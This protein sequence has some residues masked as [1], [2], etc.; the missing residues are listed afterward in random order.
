[1]RLS[2]AKAS[3]YGD[4]KPASAKDRVLL[5]HQQVL[6]YLPLP[7][8]GLF[9]LINVVIPYCFGSHV[10]VFA[11]HTHHVKL[12]S[13]Q[14]N[15]RMRGIASPPPPFTHTLPHTATLPPRTPTRSHTLPHPPSHS[16][17][18]SPPHFQLFRTTRLPHVDTSKLPPFHSSTPPLAHPHFS[19]QICDTIQLFLTDQVEVS[20]PDA[21]ATLNVSVAISTLDLRAVW[22][23]GAFNLTEHVSGL[24]IMC[25]RGETPLPTTHILS[26][27]LMHSALKVVWQK[28][29]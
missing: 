28:P 10:D 21:S 25:T 13:W 6:S 16:H 18:S 23:G 8:F 5:K 19:S 29:I 3:D 17:H 20:C 11:P 4:G 12:R 27:Y 15:L 14:Q 2:W 26:L 24:L 1:M 7:L 9:G 22:E